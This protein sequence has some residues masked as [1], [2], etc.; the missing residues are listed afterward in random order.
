MTAMPAQRPGK[1]EQD[2]TTPWR[3]IDAVEARFGRLDFDLAA[4]RENCRVRR[5]SVVQGIGNRAL[6]TRY[7]DINSLE[8]DWT[9]L[10]GNLWLNPPFGKTPEAPR[11]IEHWT[12][13][14][15]VSMRTPGRRIFL[16]APS[17]TG[18][19]W[20]ADYVWEQSRILFLKGR[21]RFVGHEND[22]PKDLLLAVYG[23]PPS[24]D[25]WDWRKRG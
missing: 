4:T 20:Y 24:I 16:L 5:S 19:C 25:L 14:C 8:Q 11:G 23:E 6:G 12:Q 13:K 22:Y 7:E 3:L 2:V 1:S 18:S 15:V 10:S 21:V 17:A 9:E